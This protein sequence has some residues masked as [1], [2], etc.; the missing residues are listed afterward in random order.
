MDVLISVS[1]LLFVVILSAWLR[2]PASTAAW[3]GVGMVAVLMYSTSSLRP[4]ATRLWEGLGAAGLITLQAILVIGPGLYLNALLGRAKAHAALV[5]WVG[6]IPMR[7]LHKRLVIIVGLA[8]ALESLTGFGVSLLV[9]V[10]L[11]LAASDRHTALRQSMLSMNIMPWGTL[12]LATVLGAQLSGQTLPSLGYVTSLISFGV[13]PA[14]A[15]LAAWFSAAPHERAMALRDGALVGSVLSVGLVVM[16]RLGFNELAGIFAGLVNAAFGLA[17]FR[18]SRAAT[19]PPWNAIKPYVI[20]IALIG[21]IRLLPFVGVNVGRWAIAAGGVHFA[22]LTSPGLALL[23]TITILSRARLSILLLRDTLSR[24]R[25]PVFALGGF[26]LMA[27]LMVASGMVRIIGEA[28]PA[29]RPEGL[30]VLS[31]LLGMLSGYLTGSNVGANALM[32]TMQAALA[33]EGKLTLLLSAAQNSAAGH[34]V[35]ASL[36]IV[37]LVL[38]IAGPGDAQEESDLVRFGLKDPVP[39][40]RHHSDVEPAADLLLRGG[41]SAHDRAKI[42]APHCSAIPAEPP[43]HQ[44]AGSI[45]SSAPSSNTVTPNS[46]AFS[47]LLPASAPA[48]T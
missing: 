43:S 25:K 13:F 32:M 3:C 5:E 22:P 42:A 31:P 10:P 17:V 27:Q 8:P 46:P 29:S 14:F 37:L 23:L 30:G 4:D 12:G 20:L 33:H 7:P 36:P 48:T 11:L 35:F 21:A 40:G 15:L 34:A 1:P 24:A 47:S 41:L 6:R 38:A 16:N 45:A 44:A 39:R 28:L 18:T 2:R 9:T 26:T 19:K